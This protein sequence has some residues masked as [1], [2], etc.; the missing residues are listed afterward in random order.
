MGLYL[1]IEKEGFNPKVGNCAKY[2]KDIIFT[3]EQMLNF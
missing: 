2:K 3:F 1:F